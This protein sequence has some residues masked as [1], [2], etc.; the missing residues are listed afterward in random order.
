MRGANVL[1]GTDADCTAWI[2]AYRDYAPTSAAAPAG[3]RAGDR[4]RGTRHGRS[5]SAAEGGRRRGGTGGETGT[6]RVMRSATRAT[7]DERPDQRRARP[8]HALRA[9]RAVSA[10]HAGARCGAL[11]RR[12]HRIG[13][14]RARHLRALPDRGRGRRVRQAQDHL[15]TDHLSPFTDTEARYVRIRGEL[16]EQRRLS[17]SATIQGDLVVDVPQDVQINRQIVRKRAETRAIERDPAIRLC[18]VEVDEPDMEKPLGDTDRL[19]R[20]LARDWRLDNRRASISTCCRR[21]RRSCA[22]ARGR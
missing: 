5:G 19:L 11:A 7:I 10:R 21:C 20:V 13:L 14:R 15:R 6:G 1:M 8:L 22:R 18:Y 16:G 17:C 9:A 4:R 3:S 2:R 12:L